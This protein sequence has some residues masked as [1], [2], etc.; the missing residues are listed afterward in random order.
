VNSLSRRWHAGRR[1]SALTASEHAR[2]FCIKTASGMD[3]DTARFTI[4][5]G[6]K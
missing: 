3:A 1:G 4:V 6:E 5:F 2:I